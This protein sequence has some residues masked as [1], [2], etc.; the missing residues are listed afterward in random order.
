MYASDTMRDAL[1][2]LTRY[3]AELSCAIDGA[4]RSGDGRGGGPIGRV[5]GAH[6]PVFARGSG[7]TSCVY[8]TARTQ[9]PGSMSE[10]ELERNSTS[11]SAIRQS[12]L[13]GPQLRQ[14]S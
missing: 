2:T 6:L 8:S 4:R 3:S 1:V 7:L 5:P 13:R 10:G 12:N 9:T 14:I 11:N